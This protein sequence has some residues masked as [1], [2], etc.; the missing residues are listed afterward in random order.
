M[1]NYDKNHAIFQYELFTA[2]ILHIQN[3]IFNSQKMSQVFQDN[4][5]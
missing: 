1:L 3:R 2:T 4:Q 5:I